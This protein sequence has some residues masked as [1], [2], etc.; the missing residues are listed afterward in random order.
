MID[1]KLANEAE[2][3]KKQA[4]HNFSPFRQE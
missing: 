3:K 1:K 2:N 4:E